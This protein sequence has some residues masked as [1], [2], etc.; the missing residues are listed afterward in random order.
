M[1]IRHPRAADVAIDVN[2]ET[3]VPDADGV[4]DIGDAS[5]WLQ[6]YAAAND[7][8]PDALLVAETCDVVKS[9]G[10]VC[11]RELPCPYHSD[12]ED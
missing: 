12:S 11:G 7:T 3:V 8:T 2:G 10:A 1:R 6:R 9:D 4:Y 5:A